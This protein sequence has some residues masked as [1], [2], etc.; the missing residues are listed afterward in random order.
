MWSEGEKASECCLQVGFFAWTSLDPRGCLLG[1]GVQAESS[2]PHGLPLPRGLPVPSSP[3]PG[4]NHALCIPT[5][6]SP[7]PWGMYLGQP[8][9]WQPLGSEDPDNCR[10]LQEER[11]SKKKKKKKY[12]R[13]VCALCTT[14][15]PGPGAVCRAPN[16]PGKH[17]V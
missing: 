2:H 13:S 11:L 8:Q 15:S 7:S 10:I 14:T 16:L 12:K 17:Q 6:V 9:T 4:C 3:S 1:R 5:P